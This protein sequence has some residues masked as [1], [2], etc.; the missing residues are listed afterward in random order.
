MTEL[1]D[2]SKA[3]LEGRAPAHKEF[4]HSLAFNLIPF[5]DTLQPNAY[6]R[7]E[8]KVAI[9]T[10]KIFG[11][12]EDELKVSCTAVRVPILRVHSEAITVQTHSPVNLERAREVLSTAAGVE[13]VDDPVKHTYPM[14]L[15][16]T[17]KL[18]VEVKVLTLA[19][20]ITPTL[21]T[22]LVFVIIRWE[23]YGNRW[24]SVAMEWIC[25]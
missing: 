1:M 20:P 14:P 6:T 12:T 24:S 8:M 4:A 10:R 3:V 23:G 18:N 7:E 5:I 13:V 25:S 9:E 22:F 21:N 19:L 16:A 17:G 2:G 11:L 15:T